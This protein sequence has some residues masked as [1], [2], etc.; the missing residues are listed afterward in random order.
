[1]HHLSYPDGSSVN[2]F[3]PHCCSTVK[4]ASV[5]DASKSIKCIG[6]GCFMAKTDIK[7]VFRI[8]PIHPADYSLLGIKWDDMYY[9]DR[10]LA[11]GL[12]SSCA[13][14][15]AFSTSLQW[16][17][18]H[19]LGACSVLHILD[20]F[21]FIVPTKEQCRR[22]LTNSVSLCN[23]LGFPLALEKTVGPAT[24]LQFTGI[25]LDSVRMEAHLPEE[26]LKKCR[27]LLTDFLSCRSVCLKELQSLIG[28]NSCLIYLTKGINKPY[29]H[30]RLSKGA[31]LD[32][33]MWLRF[34]RDLNSRSFLLE[35]IWEMSHT[36]QLY[37]DSTSSIGFGAVFGTHWSH[38]LWP[39]T[40]N[41]YNIVILELFPIVIAVHIWGPYMAD[42]CVIFYSDN[43]TVVDI[44]NKQTSKDTAIMVLLRDL[45]LSCLKHNVIFLGLSILVPIAFHV[46]RSRSS[47]KYHQT[48]TNFRLTCPR[49]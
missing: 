3:I 4:Y 7:S 40:W 31:R 20:D 9:F 46:L 11:L 14:L 39:T 30:I 17:S 5:G 44:I 34:L 48:Q 23:H 37:T 16:I 19:L 27:N 38:S 28:F 21:L 33:D 2:D 6:R 35:D 42:K 36:L 29:Y 24:V 18:V 49:T 13:I 26:K 41:S 25:T 45:I 15:G 32:L 8:I 43:A 1:M 47:R 10:C 22:D 12:R